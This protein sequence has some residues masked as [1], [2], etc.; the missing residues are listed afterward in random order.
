MSDAIKRAILQKFHQFFALRFYNAL[1]MFCDIKLWAF[2]MTAFIAIGYCIRM[3]CDKYI[4]RGK[5]SISRS[6]L[7]W[8]NRSATRTRWCILMNALPVAASRCFSLMNAHRVGT[9][10]SDASARSESGCIPE[11]KLSSRSSDFASRYIRVRARCLSQR[12]A[13]R[14]C[15]MP[16]NLDSEPRRSFH[17]SPYIFWIRRCL[18]VCATDTR[19][20]AYPSI[21]VVDCSLRRAQKLRA[22]IIRFDKIYN[23]VYKLN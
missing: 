7:A 5:Y 13:C 12:N 20:P 18:S 15:H 17:R 23:C 1:R 19:L 3:H 6:D 2:D 4:R 8:L 9:R 22:G 10:A 14:S 16:G 11:D 21:S